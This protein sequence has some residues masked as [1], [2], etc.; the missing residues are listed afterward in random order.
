MGVLMDER[1][2]ARIKSTA[3]VTIF[4]RPDAGPL[5][6]PIDHLPGLATSG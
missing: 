3:P 2:Q 6:R 5:Q 4:D 1:G